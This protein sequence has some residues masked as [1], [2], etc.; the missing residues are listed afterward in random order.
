MFAKILSKISS[1][2]GRHLDFLKKTFSDDGIPSM[3]RIM[4][5]P[6][7]LIA[8]WAVVYIVLHTHGIGLDTATGLGAF[9]TVHYGVNKIT[10]I[11]TKKDAPTDDAAKEAA[12]G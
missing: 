10:K 2:A 1:L 5:V 4:T 11:F 7:S 9:A 12:N 8:C 6:H 3:S